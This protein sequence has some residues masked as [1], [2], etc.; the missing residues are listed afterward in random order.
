MRKHK[1]AIQTQAPLGTNYGNTLQAFA[2]Q[3]FLNN[4][5]QDVIVLDRV[6][7]DIYGVTHWG[8]SNFKNE[9]LNFIDKKNRLTPRTFNQIFKQHF[10]FVYEKIRLSERLH[11]S[12]ELENHFKNNAY[13][14]VIVGSDQTWR[15]QY[16][17]NIYNYFLDFLVDNN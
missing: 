15:P 8:L 1:I 16:S 6:K 7:S 2:L 14:M 4:H 5:Q 3:K 11:N 17:P 10:Q 12:L 9:I 13:I